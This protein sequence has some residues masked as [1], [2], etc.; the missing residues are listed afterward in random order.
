MNYAIL[1]AGGK[2]ER[3]L[4]ASVPKQFAELCGVP[5]LVYSLRAAEMS[6]L[7]DE[8]C[9]VCPESW[10]KTV[11]E[12]LDKYN[13]KKVKNMAMAGTNR[14]ESVYNGLKQI[15]AK[16]PDNVIILTAVC[17]FLSQKTIINNFNALKKYEACI[18]VVKATDAITFSTD[19]KTATRTMQKKKMFIQQGPQSFHYKTLM[20]AHKYYEQE[21]ELGTN[22]LHEINED[23]EIVLNMGVEVAMA[24]GDRFC[25]KVTYPEDL[26]IASA[27]RGLFEK[28]EGMG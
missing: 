25:I 18:T 5:M 4:N 28:S 23:S 7:I 21:L 15:E 9:V 22:P 1:L 17:P 16:A 24:L 13:I 14:R 8:V 10:S 2:G 6:P 11:G 3:F 12:W 20:Q 19:G 26:A 27:L